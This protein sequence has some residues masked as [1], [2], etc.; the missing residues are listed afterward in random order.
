VAAA[1]SLDRWSVLDGLTALVGQSLLAEEEG[2]G[3]DSRYRL[4]E[5]MRAFARQHVTVGQLTRLDRAHARF[6]A[7][8]AD[9]AG[10]E[11]FG[12]EQLDWQHRIRAERD[13][14]HAAVTWALARGG[15][16]PGSPSG[17]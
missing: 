1:V 8:F 17:S 15:H 9:R 3:D 2:P 16:D 5:T 11:V 10:P 7:A 6:Y 14:L 13:N 12:P 4:L